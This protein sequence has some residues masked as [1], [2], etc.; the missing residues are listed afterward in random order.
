MAGETI[1]LDATAISVGR[2]QLDIT[3]YVAAA[4]PNWGDAEIQAYMADQQ[5]GSTTVDYRLPNR[6]ITIPLMLR[7]L[8]ATTFSTIRSN[9]EQKVGL[10]QRQQ[11]W[12]MRQVGATNLY[13]DVVS[14]TLHLGGAWLQAYRDV[15]VDAV[16]T[17]ECIP[18]WY[19]DEITLT[20][21]VETILPHLLFTEPV[22]NGNHP[23]RV[24]LV[25]DNDQSGQDKHGLL[26]GFRAQNYNAGTTAALFYEAEALVPINSATRNA[27][28]GAS[29][30]SVVTLSSP[31]GNVWV[32]MLRM[33]MQAGTTALTH[34]GEYRVWARCYSSSGLAQYRLQWGVGDLAVPAVNDPAQIPGTGNFYLLDLG[35]VSLDPPPAGIMQWQGVIQT[36]VPIA[37]QPATIDSVYFQPLDESA[38]R[39][40]YTPTSPASS[41][42]AAFPT[43][44]TIVD[45]ASSGSTAWTNPMNA[46]VQEGLLAITT[47]PAGSTSHFLKAT[48]WLTIPSTAVIQGI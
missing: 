22:V 24:R 7:S 47:I 40:I 12:I 27:F 15:D 41:I 30:G 13:A 20:D 29:G 11:G 34:S 10:F 43:A 3:G 46:Q 25:V 21:H 31:P 19:G 48:N 23:G 32:P 45:D 18:D 5:V 8:G 17:L 44:G 6:T 2:T 36:Q 38:G 9:L 26:W 16:L 37:N 1:I 14:A 39:L 42:E 35:S 33:S 28:A 4:G